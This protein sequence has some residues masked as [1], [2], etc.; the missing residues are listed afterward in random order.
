MG[1]HISFMHCRTIF[2][3]CSDEDNIKLF[4]PATPWPNIVWVLTP[5]GPSQQLDLPFSI[6][7][8]LVTH[9]LAT[10]GI[11]LAPTVLTCMQSRKYLRGNSKCQEYGH[12]VIFFVKGY[13][14]I[15]WSTS[16]TIDAIVAHRVSPNWVQSEQG[17]DVPEIN[18]RQLQTNITKDMNFS[19]K[20]I[21]V[22]IQCTA[23]YAQCK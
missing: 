20:K 18:R 13:C 9:F 23:V 11:F 12:E 8:C 6:M 17:N 15:N 4:S 16:Y 1:Y 10:R 2:Q 14:N 5:W 22:I 3:R 21:N 7:W 19:G